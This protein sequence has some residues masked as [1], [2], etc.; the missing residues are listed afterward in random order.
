MSYLTVIMILIGIIAYFKLSDPENRSD[1]KGFFYILSIYYQ[2][3]FKPGIF[4][5]LILPTFDL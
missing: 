2:K 5:L 4:K 3:I 1:N